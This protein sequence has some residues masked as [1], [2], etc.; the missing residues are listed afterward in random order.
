MVQATPAIDKAKAQ[1]QALLNLIEKLDEELSAATEDY[2]YAAQELEDTQAKV[3]KTTSNI[4]KAE[5]DLKTAQDQLN[6]R[7]VNIYKAG[8]LTM[9]NVMLDTTASPT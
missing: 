5:K 4:A 3:K 9:L 2:D 7:L 8:N 6:Q 1:A